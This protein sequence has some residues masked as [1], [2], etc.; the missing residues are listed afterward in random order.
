MKKQLLKGFLAITLLTLTAC[1]SIKTAIY[2]Q[3]SYQ[4][5]IALKVETNSLLN[6]ATEPYTDYKE[7]V[8]KL[9]LEMEKMEEYEKN[10]PN[11]SISYKMWEL[12]TDEERNSVAGLFKMWKEKGQL[13]AVFLEESK[14]Q[15]SQAFDALIKYEVSKDKEKE[16]LL[17]EILK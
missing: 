9:L 17:L 3:Y 8:E 13:S 2:D 15:V 4:Q 10:K 11:N 5:E 1:N 6:H 7:E 12:M 16:N 14:V